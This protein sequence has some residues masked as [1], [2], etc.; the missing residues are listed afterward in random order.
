MKRT[1]DVVTRQ[2]GL[3]LERPQHHPLTEETHEALIQAL[4]DLLLEAYGDDRSN[5]HQLRG[6]AD[7]PEADI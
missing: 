4:A 5:A 1:S 3:L 2:L 7:E 6:G